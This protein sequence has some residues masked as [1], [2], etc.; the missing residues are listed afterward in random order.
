MMGH[1]SFYHDRF[2]NSVG[3]FN[4]RPRLSVH[5][6]QRLSFL[7][8]DDLINVVNYDDVIDAVKFDYD[9]V[10]N[11]FVLDNNDIKRS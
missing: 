5:S 8:Y 7:D 4:F 1:E 2:E 3:Y 11:F 10:I 9:D 6:F